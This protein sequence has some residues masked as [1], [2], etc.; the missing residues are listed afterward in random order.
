MHMGGHG[1]AV[2]MDLSLLQAGAA[3][4]GGVARYTVPS[5][6]AGSGGAAGGGT[7]QGRGGAAG[8]GSAAGRGGQARAQ[9]HDDE[10][11]DGHSN[12][13]GGVIDDD[14]RALMDR[15]MSRGGA[16]ATGVAAQAGGRP[17]G[18][19]GRDARVSHTTDD[20]DEGDASPALTAAAARSAAQRGAAAYGG[21][22]LA[23]GA[24]AAR[25]GVGVDE[26]ETDGHD[27][28]DFDDSDAV[29]NEQAETPA[30]G[31]GG[32]GGGPGSY[33]PYQQQVARALA[34]GPRG[35]SGY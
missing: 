25:G 13:D 32:G 28:H 9:A 26:W 24:V 2:A 21:S 10:S 33:R 7:V 6:Y 5:G 30:S 20:D 3:G 35:G 14:I 4:G 1:E 11:G 8:V 31:G 17:A 23:S 15:Y 19:L 34:T 12:A 27:D 18:G 16:G 29:M 22:G